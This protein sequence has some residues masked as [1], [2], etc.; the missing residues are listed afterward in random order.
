MRST[1]EKIYFRKIKRIMLSLLEGQ[2]RILLQFLIG[3]HCISRQRVLAADKNMRSCNKQRMKFQSRVTLKSYP[4]PFTLKSFRNKIPISLL[5]LATSSYK[6]H[7]SAFSRRL[8][9]YSSCP[10]SLNQIHKCIHRK[11]IVL[12]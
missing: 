3:N 8:K 11:R 4:K 2:I 5:I 9:S 6:F 12:C 1:A 10:Y 7:R